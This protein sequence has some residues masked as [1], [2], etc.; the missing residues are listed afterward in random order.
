MSWKSSSLATAIQQAN[1]PSVQYQL[2]KL[3]TAAVIALLQPTVLGVCGAT[4]SSIF[5]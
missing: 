5:V 2:V 1:V 3:H 4:V